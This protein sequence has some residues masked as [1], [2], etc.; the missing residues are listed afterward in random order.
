MSKHGSRL[1]RLRGGSA[2]S[3]P[4]YTCGR[5]K[6]TWKDLRYPNGPH[7]RTWNERHHRRSSHLQLSV[8]AGWSLNKTPISMW[9]FHG[10]I[11][12]PSERCSA[13]NCHAS[14]AHVLG[15]R[16]F[17]LNPYM[18]GKCTIESHVHCEM[19]TRR[20]GWMTVRRTLLDNS[21]QKKPDSAQIKCSSKLG[22]KLLEVK[23]SFLH[24]QWNVQ[25]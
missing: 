3:E 23:S 17:R 20:Y 9:S 7:A 1:L 5:T 25:G 19:D 6:S 22:K 24:L 4:G 15:A 13:C 21:Q 12:N 8:V 2:R 14:F 11:C 10:E 16:V 18:S